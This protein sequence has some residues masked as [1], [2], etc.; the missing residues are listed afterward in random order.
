MDL[1]DAIRA[2]D[3]PHEDDILN[4]LYTPWGENLDK[5]N[6]L[7]E[8]PRPQFQR[9][10][11]INL[12]GDWEYCIVPEEQGSS[13]P[14]KM[15][16]HI[17]VPFS[18][19]AMLSGVERRLEPYQYLWY[20]KVLP[21]LK[22]THHNSR[23][24]LHFGAVDQFADIY[25]N[26]T[27][28]GSHS[29]GYLPFTLDITD[30]LLF[31]G[32]NKESLDNMLHV[33][34]KDT[35]DSSYHSRGKQTLKRGGMYYTCQSGIWQTVWI[36]E[37]PNTYIRKL[38]IRPEADL[39][40]LS[41][42]VST[43]NPSKVTVK[44]P[45]YEMVKSPSSSDSYD[46]T[47]T[48]DFSFSSDTYPSIGEDHSAISPSYYHFSFTIKEP[49]LWS[50]EDPYLYPLQ[51][52][53]DEDHVDSYFAMRYYSIE[54]DG[55][56]ISRFCLNHAPYFLMGALD[57]GYWPDGLYTAPS[58][59][60]LIYDITEMKRLHF[61][62]L[63][64]HIKVEAARWY[65]HCD[66]LGMIVWQDMV[67][68]GSSYAKP[69]V[70]Y[71]PTLFPKVFGR[72][73]DGP[74]T[75]KTF[76][77]GSAEGRG[78]WLKEMQNTIR[79]LYNVPSIATWVLFNEGWGQFNA[80]SA[81]IIAREID[82]TRPIDQ[83]SGWFDEGSGDYRSVHNYFRPLTVEK[84]PNGRAFVIS[85]YGGFTHHIAGHSSVDRVFGYK[86]YDTLDQLGV[87][88]YNLMNGTIKPLITKGLAGAVYTQ[89]SDVEEE[90]NGLMTYD[91]RITKINPDLDPSLSSNID[92]A[93][94]KSQPDH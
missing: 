5:D 85:E 4:R 45:G 6:V 20:K 63:R 53:T 60:A 10:S 59:K 67:S 22:R 40:T 30:Y 71:L 32:H 86:K 74:A 88:Y 3:K 18:P 39:K 15:D 49:H 26:S 87:A 57:Q 14:E 58:D 7:K 28:V 54:K 1:I 61:N 17:L 47:F 42:E 66:R 43:N 79:Y 72:M 77:R 62:M 12:N 52:I 51:I 70:S 65:Y 33:R 94:N 34:V 24:L 69:V 16:G 44:F 56:G 55:S 27:L 11:Y 75:Y 76:S 78:E 21:V 84:D 48:G 50:P 92:I 29:G 93:L 19:E 46:T 41:I 2:I 81:T 73:P 89:V 23:F 82:N 36:E 25:V 91:R 35:S 38:R 80:A 9:N 13:I 31:D 64:K 83:A 37:V 8:Y 68:G 90:V